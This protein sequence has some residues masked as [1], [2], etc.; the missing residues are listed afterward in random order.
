MSGWPS[1]PSVYEINSWVWLRELSL[2]EGRA[3][4]FGDV[5]EEELERLATFRFD[6]LW[7]MG[8]WERSPA[9]REIA[10]QNPNLRQGY[11][12]ALLDFA[13]N[14]VVGSP[15]A[16][17]GYVVD[18]A[19][20]GNAGLASLRRQL[21][22]RGMRLIL[23]F[24]PNH[25][26]RDHPWLS[27]HPERFVRGSDTSLRDEAG[28]YF[29]CAGGS[30]AH[31]R[32]PHWAA[33]TDT[34]QLDY[35]LENT[36]E[37]M[38]ATLLS[39][40][41]QCDG[42]R[43]DMAMLVTRGIFLRTW[44]GD[45]TPN[46]GEFWPKAIADLREKHPDFLMLAEAYWNTEFDLQQQGFDYT[47]DKVLYDHLCAQDVDAVKVHLR[48]D[49]GFQRRLARFIE[50][51]D[52]ERSLHVF[53]SQ[54]TRAVATLALGLPGLRLFH[55]GQLD[56][57]LGTLPV[58][59]GRRLREDG[60]D[61]IKGFYGRL[62]LALREP[63]FHQGRWLLLDS[64]PASNGN[65]SHRNFV[66]YQWALGGE[67]R[68]VVVNLA[69]APSQC[70]LQLRELDEKCSQWLLE[71]LLGDAQYA[72]D[73]RGR[74]LFL[75]L[76]AHGY[77]LFRVREE[78]S[79]SPGLKLRTV[80]RGHHAA[81]Y[82]VAWSPDGH[83]LASAGAERKLRVW[84]VDSSQPIAEWGEHSAAVDSIAWSPDGRLIA[85]GSDDHTVSLWD[86]ENQVQRVFGKGAHDNN[87]LAVAW[88][89]DSRA[90]ASGGIDRLI[91]VWDPETGVV[92][93]TLR[94]QEDAINC[95]AWAP[96][97]KTLASGSGDRTVRLWDMETGSHRVLEGSDW[98]SSAAWSPDS[99]YLASGTGAG[100]VDIWDAGA[101]SHVATCEGH[102]RRVLAVA[103]S[104]DGRLLSSKSADGT[105]K[106]WEVGSWELVSTMREDGEY[107]AGLAFQRSGAMLA[108]RHDTE[109]TIRIWEVDS[110]RMLKAVERH[111]GLSVRHMTGKIVLLGD[112]SV[113]KSGLGYTLVHGEFKE[114]ASTHGQQFWVFPAVSQRRA[115]GTACEA[116]LW[117]FAGQPD[118]RLVHALFVDD[119]DLALV[120]FDAS[121]LHEPLH[122]VSFWL[123]QLQIGR[124]RC[125]IILVAAQ[126]DRGSCSL[127]PEELRAFCRRH[128]IEGPITTSAKEG[129]G[130][131][132]LVDRIKSLIPWEEKAATVTTTTF[133]RIKDYV[134]GLKEAQADGRTIVTAEELRHRLET[135]DANWR[136]TDAEM[137]TAVGHLENYGYVRRLRTSRGDQRLLLQPEL[138]N[139]LASSFVLEARRNPKGLGALEE[140]RLLAGG[141]DFPELTNLHAPERDVLLDSVALLF[142]EHHVC[143]READPLRMEPYLIFPEL[144]NLKRPPEEEQATEESVA[145]TVSGPIENVFASLVV[146]LGYTHTFTRTAQWQ[147]N[148]RYEV[149]EG[150]VCGFRQEAERDGELDFVL[151]FGPQ[152]GP[153]VRTLFQGL[154]ESFLARRNLTVMRH[155]PVH[156][157]KGHLLNRA[158]A[159]ELM[160]H[161]DENAFCSKCGEM[162]RLP[163]MAEPIQLTREVQAEVESGRRTA[164][165]RT[166]FEQALFRVRAYV[167]EHNIT[168]P[169]CFISYAWGVAEHERWVEKRLATDL[170]KAG[171][172]VVL[173]R[174]DNAQIGASVPRFIERIEKSDRVIMV[175]TPLYRRK[176]QNQ[177]SSTGYVVAAEVDMIAN[178]LLGT[179][180]QKASV[181]PLLLDGEK[182]ASLP[183][184]LATRVHADFRDESAY[185]TSVFDLILSLY[186][187]PP[188]HPAVADLRESLR[189][190]G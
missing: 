114:Q 14:D 137:L 46:D 59:L 7:L 58:Q 186:Q 92:R 93:R 87:V 2:S 169:E 84:D 12:R 100:N 160:Q 86:V 111:A 74:G 68:L 32:D 136:F 144:I 31:G 43:C 94:G 150:L 97:G 182:A 29:A 119:A 187:L 89:P 171:I 147:N 120:L 44:G 112:H 123:K 90:L 105:V 73:L 69:A 146:L 166:R 38:A 143:F 61:S 106:F 158:V 54:R 133:K 101:G 53:G 67:W 153:P 121:H 10:L 4:T 161:G 11:R 109:N 149:G 168:P 8:V 88:S 18:E 178:R 28:N 156:C 60:E 116:I 117:D 63:V 34:A 6:A 139:N 23:D 177:D 155:E 50:N 82:G 183:P 104:P 41:D 138:L 35:R 184:L 145:Y 70:F 24:V 124:K 71:D 126:T 127:T 134:L 78:E 77:H 25:L 135:T 141:Y 122:G 56:G 96:D 174:W 173:D 75:D 164:E 118:Y 52:E 132:E 102:T 20:G 131:E 175:G 26:A 113:G 80:L 167:G 30:F 13:E 51:H 17:Y 9:G 188:N 16:V 152:V 95:L 33:W 40:A 180:T 142:L 22:E 72:R 99:A 172:G 45:F 157:T 85:S 48:A 64:R 163:K 108:T 49:M 148:A 42:V 55:E 65:E 1:F 110:D 159:R 103:F 62:L 39:V 37:A 76:P 181:L 79:P 185:F 47:Y 19:L 57:Y 5:P 36:R 176:Y 21:H 130:L 115:D 91:K 151:C 165:Q 128:A 83:K 179:E 162:L 190:R 125:P 66:A 154:F 129:V 81:I 140:R 170:Q 15:Y 189:Q 3:I 98:V 107:L 27:E